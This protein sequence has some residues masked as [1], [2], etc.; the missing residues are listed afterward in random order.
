MSVRANGDVVACC[1]D[2]TSQLTLGNVLRDD[3]ADIWNGERYLRLR[4]EIATRVYNPTCGNCNTVRRRMLIVPKPEVK[5]R[6]R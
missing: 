4:Q 6:L 2:L 5:A 1:Y 3:L